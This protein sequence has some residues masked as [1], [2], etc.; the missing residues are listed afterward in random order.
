MIYYNFSFFYNN[1]EIFLNEWVDNYKII[2][3]IHPPQIENVYYEENEYYDNSFYIFI[4]Y[5]DEI[6]Y[7]LANNLV[8]SYKNNGKEEYKVLTNPIYMENLDIYKYEINFEKNNTND[9]S[10]F[11]FINSGYFEYDYLNNSFVKNYKD[12]KNYLSTTGY[13]YFFKE[14]N[15][16]K[17]FN[18]LNIDVIDS[19][20]TKKG[21]KYYLDVFYHS[22]KIWNNTKNGNLNLIKEINFNY[23]LYDNQNNKIKKYSKKLYYSKINFINYKNNIEA[24]YEIPTFEE[25]NIYINMNFS[26][27]KLNFKY[28]EKYFL[29]KK[30][31]VTDFSNV[32]IENIKIKKIKNNS[33]TFEITYSDVSKIQAN[34]L[35]ITYKDSNNN[36]YDSLKEE[37]LISNSIIYEN[38][39]E[40]T[41]TNLENNTKYSNFNIY[42]INELNNDYKYDWSYSYFNDYIYPN[43]Y[44]N[45]SIKTKNKK[46]IVILSLI[47]S[48]FYI[49]TFVF[50]LIK[51]IKYKKSIL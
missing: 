3:P 15:F 8:L 30:N 14:I 48:L 39:Y 2:T 47:I 33:I 43:N 11:V 42:A 29:N 1:E 50:F 24:I 9:L 10:S 37:N 32:N 22:N 31:Y 41:L 25:N 18:K 21:N 38:Q 45:I 34:N 26:L 17:N 44:E 5:N 23:S 28:N 20:I 4:K 51:Y 36:E 27:S 12:N 7:Q 35:R 49:S 46:L 16:E 40:Y 19:K 6:N 13:K